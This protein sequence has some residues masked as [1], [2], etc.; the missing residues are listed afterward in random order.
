M[1]GARPLPRDDAAVGVRRVGRAKG[2][3]ARQGLVDE[4]AERP[5][6]GSFP[7]PPVEEDFGGDVVR[8]AA[9]GVGS[10]AAREDL[11]R[12]GEKEREIVFF[13]FFLEKRFCSRE[14]E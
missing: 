10:A 12:R 8:G 5:P 1:R 3:E 6:V 11:L 9:E 4:D 2:R 7:V 14:R 13:F